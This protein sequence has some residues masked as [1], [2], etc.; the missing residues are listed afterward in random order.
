MEQIQARK[1]LSIIIESNNIKYQ[2][3]YKQKTYRTT[4][5]IIT[6]V[7]NKMNK[8]LCKLIEWIYRDRKIISNK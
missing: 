1:W 8:Q 3:R 5:I 2:S 6:K 4:K 7:N